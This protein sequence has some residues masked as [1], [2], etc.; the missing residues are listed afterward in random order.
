MPKVFR[1]KLLEGIRG[2]APTL[3]LGGSAAHLAAP[4]AL[5]ALV[6]GLFSRD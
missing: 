3:D 4:G 2:L 1:A 6:D 5:S